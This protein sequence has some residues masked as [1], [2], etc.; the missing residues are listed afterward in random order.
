MD[1]GECA[2]SGK[3]LGKL[4]RPGIMAVLANG[5]VH[6]Y[7]IAQQLKALS[8]FAKGEPDHAGVYRALKAMEEE[9]YVSSKWDL[10]DT[11]PAR[12]QYALTRAG[13]ECL[14]TWLKTLRQ[15]RE[16]IADLLKFAE[17]QTTGAGRTKSGRCAIG[18]LSRLARS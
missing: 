3:T 18:A 8:M 15:Y 7:R 2:C 13:R 9:G 16:A 12:R 10:G 4:L 17:A 5:P 11:G 1:F 6:G 14:T